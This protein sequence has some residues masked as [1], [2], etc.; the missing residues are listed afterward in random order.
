M[1]ERSAE[2]EVTSPNHATSNTY[3]PPCFAFS[4]RQFTGPVDSDVAQD[5]V[6]AAPE[7]YHWSEF[8]ESN[9]IL[10]EAFS[11]SA[12]SNSSLVG[13]VR[14]GEG[15]DAQQRIYGGGVNLKVGGA[16]GE[17][18]KIL[19]AYTPTTLR[20][21]SHI[22]GRDCLHYCLPGPVDHWITLLYNI[23]LQQKADMSHRGEGPLL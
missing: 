1:S 9:T 21:D 4:R 5:M 20:A 13:G 7:D 2:N 11:V 6:D 12:S 22:G 15:R 16:A 14:D 18:W 3:Q 19:D 10:E 23:I 8:R 17:G